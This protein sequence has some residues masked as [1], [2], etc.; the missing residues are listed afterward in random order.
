M[1]KS[2][3]IGRLRKA[4]LNLTVPRRAVMALLEKRHGEHLSAE[5]IHGT[6]SAEGVTVDLSSVYRTLNVLVSLGLVHRMDLLESHTHF[7]VENGEQAHLRCEM[8]GEVSEVYLSRDEELAQ[9]VQEVARKRS[10][11][12]IRFRVEAEG[13][14]RRCALQ[15][16]RD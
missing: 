9:R 12:L 11:E 2:D 1:S 15:L 4:G 16:Q 5:E 3:L 7:G 13:K 10:F 14:C 8:C 6:L